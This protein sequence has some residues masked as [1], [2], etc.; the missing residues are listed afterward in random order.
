L[1]HGARGFRVVVSQRCE[2][3]PTID[4]H[5]LAIVHVDSFYE[6]ARSSKKSL[7]RLRAFS[8]RK[9]GRVFMES[10]ILAQD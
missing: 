7:E 10:L 4:R 2:G 6:S 9:S 8:V 1:K 5:G 3:A